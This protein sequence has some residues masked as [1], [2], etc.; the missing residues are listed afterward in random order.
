MNVNCQIKLAVE[1][2][3][4]CSSSSHDDWLIPACHSNLGDTLIANQQQQQQQQH[5][6]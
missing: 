2:L 4:W 3:A 6:S 1:R 5:S